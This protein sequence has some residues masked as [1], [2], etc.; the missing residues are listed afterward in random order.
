MQLLNSRLTAGQ[1]VF[2]GS[3]ANARHARKVHRPQQRLGMTSVAVAAVEDPQTSSD[4]SKEEAYQRF[5]ALLD[6]YTVSFATGDKV[7]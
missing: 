6:E 1:A 5:E 2:G 3:T 4:L 7:G